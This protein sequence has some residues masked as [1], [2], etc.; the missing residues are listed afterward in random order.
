MGDDMKREYPILFPNDLTHK[1][2]ADALQRGCPELR[3]ATVVGAGEMSCMD[4]TPDCHGKS[5]TLGVESRGKLDDAAFN[6][7]D[8][9]HGVVDA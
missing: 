8:Y 3:R 6:M 5:V 1:D 2:V 9:H 4:V 7:R